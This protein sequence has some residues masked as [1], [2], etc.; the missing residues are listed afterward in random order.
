M[1]NNLSLFSKIA[2]IREEFY[3]QPVRKT[4]ENKFSGFKYFELSDILPVAMPI[5]S[6]YKVTPIISF[7]KELADMTIYDGESE[8]SIKI[9]SPSVE[10]KLKGCTDVQN[11]GA[12]QTYLRRYL[13][14]TFLE[15]A[16]NDELDK[17][18]G[19]PETKM[20]PPKQAWTPESEE[21][22]KI[23]AKIKELKITPETFERVLNENFNLSLSSYKNM[24]LK[25]LKELYKII[26][27][28]I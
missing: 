23:S 19:Q 6:K 10:V 14:L 13:W 8:Q 1:E 12:E 3:A 5:L 28:I 17:F 20:Q 22:K 26:G 15:V 7:G 11:L 27:G 2:K 18:T 21:R 24:N 16:E 9:Q 25:A 4:G